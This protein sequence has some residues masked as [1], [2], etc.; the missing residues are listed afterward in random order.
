MIR[1]VTVAAL[2]VLAGCGSS[3]RDAVARGE[4][5]LYPNETPELRRLINY[6]AEIGRASCRERV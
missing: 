3:G 4:P 2:L 5:P 1:I 6:Y